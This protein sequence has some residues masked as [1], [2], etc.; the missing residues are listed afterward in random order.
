[1]HK[2]VLRPSS[3]L[4]IQTDLLRL[5]V[6]LNNRKKLRQTTIS[7]PLIFVCYKWIPPPACF[8]KTQMFPVYV[9]FKRTIG[10]VSHRDGSKIFIFVVFFE[11]SDDVFDLLV[12][13]LAADEEGIRSVH[14]Y[15]VFDPH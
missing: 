2:F 7:Q 9:I 8:A 5:S 1:M 3:I 11:A 14:H 10:I 6:G 15:E 4:P 12:L 13:V